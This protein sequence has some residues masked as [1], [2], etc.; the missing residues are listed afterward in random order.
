MSRLHTYLALGL[1]VMCTTANAANLIFD[2]DPFAGTNASN[3][4]R[5]IVNGPGEE[6]TF[7]IGSDVLMFDLSVFGLTQLSFANGL[8]TNLPTTGIN[9]IVLNNGGPLAA[10]TAANAIADQVTE[11]GPGFFIYFN[12]TLNLPRLVYST[13]LNSTTSDLSILARFTNLG[14]TEGFAA[15]PTV[16]PGN[17]GEVPEPS[18][19]LLASAGALLIGARSWRRR[20][21]QE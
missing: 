14:G 17:V 3:P 10:G 11:S 2:D 19:L 12:S 18:S 20:R 21:T 7:N 4:G 8:S 13:D 1:F 6:F 9:F 16:T 15:L 5:Q